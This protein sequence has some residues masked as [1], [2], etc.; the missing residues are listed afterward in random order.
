MHIVA[1][2]EHSNFLELAIT[3]LE[4]KGIEKNRICAIPLNKMVK[5]RALID[6]LHQA[7]GQSMFD[8]PAI[9]ATISMTLG[10]A[11]GFMW[12]WGPIIW[13]LLAF[14]G[15]L[16]VGLVI[17]YLLY[18]NSLKENFRCNTEVVLIVDCKAD[19]LETVETVLFNHLAIGIGRKA[20][21]VR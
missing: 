9:L 19:E 8:L 11:W 4:Q 7:D 13:G 16:A 1:S 20:S 21:E 18:K 17:K 6:T 14:I 2:F 12:K 10:V 5:E 3:D 15:G